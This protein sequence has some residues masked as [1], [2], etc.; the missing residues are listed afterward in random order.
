MSHIKHQCSAIS[1]L[2]QQRQFGSWSEYQVHQRQE[3]QRQSILRF[4]LHLQRLVN[5]SKT[6]THVHASS[7]ESVVLQEVSDLAD[8]FMTANSCT[9]LSHLSPST[10]RCLQWDHVQ[11]QILSLLQHNHG[12][13]L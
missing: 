4:T 8:A 13:S 6:A 5:A 11:S 10:G 1:G 3:G 7:K 12:P 2:E 9:L